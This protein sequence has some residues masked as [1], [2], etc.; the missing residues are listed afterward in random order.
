MALGISTACLYPMVMEDSLQAL[1]DLGFQEF[2]IFINTYSEM[3]PEFLA[4]LEKKLKAGGSRVKSLHP[5]TSG[6]E[7]YLLFSN[8][9]RR[10]QDG[11]SFYRR[12]FEM[13]QRLGAEIVV[14]HGDRSF[15][16]SG[17]SDREYYD[18]F[19]ALSQI[20]GKYGVTLAQEN[21][22][23]FRSQDCGFIREMREYLKDD[24]KFVLDIKQ[25]VRAGR[26]PYEMCEA[27]GENLVHVHINDNIPGRDC[28]LPGRG[29]MDYGKLREILIKNRYHGDF[30][31]EVYRKD[32]VKLSELIDA[33]HFLQPIFL[34]PNFG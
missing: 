15:E 27:M 10:F 11:A 6:F 21:V 23:A 3:E 14:I 5:F 13:A 12:Y 2:E 9:E 29:V 4:M 16:K 22:N 20:A 28:L 26:D 24:G 30:I 18:R 17:L 25:A 32:F 1:I 8:Y 19:G 33:Y 34:E 31:I 7:S